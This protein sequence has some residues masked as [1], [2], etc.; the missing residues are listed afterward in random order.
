MGESGECSGGWKGGW[1]GLEGNK[2]REFP[3]FLCRVTRQQVIKKT[4]PDMESR[5]D[6]LPP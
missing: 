4:I 6:I 2:C 5:F 1:V 3:T